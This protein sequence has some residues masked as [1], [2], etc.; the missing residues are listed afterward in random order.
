MALA[1]AAASDIGLVRG[2]NEDAWLARPDLGL[3]VVADG[4]GGHS[5]GEVASALA[6][7]AIES[8]VGRGLDLADAVRSGH[9]SILEAAATG[10]GAPGMGSTVVALHIQEHHYRIAWVGDSRAYL[11]DGSELRQLTR[12]HSYVQR[13]LDNGLITPE[14]ALHHPERNTIAQ[15]LGVAG[16]GLSVDVVE[17]ALFQHDQILLCSDGLTGEVRDA[18]IAH[19]LASG[20]PQQKVDALVRAALDH[21]G[22]D[23][24]TVMLVSAPQDARVRPPRAKTVPIDSARL[25]QLL[26]RREL[27]RR[28]LPLTGISLAVMLMLGGLGW[29]VSQRPVDS[30]ELVGSGAS[31]QRE[32]VGTLEMDVPQGSGAGNGSKDH[33]DILYGRSAGSAAY[34][35]QSEFPAAG[36]GEDGRADPG[37]RHREEEAVDGG[38]AAR[39]HQGPAE[40]R[41]Q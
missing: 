37:G 1:Y 40:D 41:N 23:N 11:W 26:R 32:A 7:Q 2:H 35:G 19:R 25:N 18:E 39:D 16:A 5:A 34:G 22:S 9:G 20:N 10:H 33:E 27:A 31:L 3:W 12:D 15:A 28:W 6:V 38:A 30:S 29:W 14:Q 36:I 4:M 21:G 17:G 24:V 8:A 13:L